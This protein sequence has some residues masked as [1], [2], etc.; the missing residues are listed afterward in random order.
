[1]EIIQSDRSSCVCDSEVASFFSSLF[2]FLLFKGRSAAGGRRGVVD[3]QGEEYIISY[4]VYY[5]G[6]VGDFLHSFVVTHNGKSF[7]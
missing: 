7:L 1:M 4:L 2:I 6:R 5:I 3:T